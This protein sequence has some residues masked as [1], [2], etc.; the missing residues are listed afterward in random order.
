MLC[1][2]PG[3]VQVRYLTLRA[4]LQHVEGDQPRL[5]RMLHWSM[6]DCVWWHMQRLRRYRYLPHLRRVRK[7]L[8]DRAATIWQRQ[9]DRVQPLPQPLEPAQE[10]EL[11][12]V[13]ARK[14]WHGRAML[15]LASKVRVWACLHVVAPGCVACSV[16]LVCGLVVCNS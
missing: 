15:R 10:E 4:L 9:V 3:G 5:R 6:V 13:Y 8:Q 12:R 11:Q 16:C 7:A 1:H 2:T 14:R